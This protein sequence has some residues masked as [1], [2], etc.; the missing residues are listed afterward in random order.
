MSNNCN[1]IAGKKNNI[2]YY[3]YRQIRSA[4]EHDLC[5]TCSRQKKEMLYYYFPYFIH[6]FPAYYIITYNLANN[7]Y[8]LSYFILCDYAHATHD[9]TRFHE[10][11]TEYP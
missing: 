7:N 4:L 2:Y 9:K 10:Y 8:R 11:S 3:D 1:C 6:S 5:E